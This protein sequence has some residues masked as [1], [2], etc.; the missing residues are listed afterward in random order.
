MFCKIFEQNL[1]Y[2][3]IF[4]LKG[5]SGPFNGQGRVMVD[6][7]PPSIAAA[8]LGNSL[9]IVSASKVDIVKVLLRDIF[10]FVTVFFYY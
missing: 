6:N 9:R 3:P 2:A 5:K 4:G 1:V 10:F 8:G 7:L